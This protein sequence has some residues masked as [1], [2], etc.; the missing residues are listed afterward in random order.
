MVLHSHTILTFCEE[1]VFESL[2]WYDKNLMVQA[3]FRKSLILFI[4]IYITNRSIWYIVF[5]TKPTGCGDILGRP[6]RFDWGTILHEQNICLIMLYA[7]IGV[8]ETRAMVWKRR[9][10]PPSFSY[11]LWPSRLHPLFLCL[12]ISECFKAHF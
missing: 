3:L 6:S 5:S 7:N 10:V 4:K 2:F 12:N 9:G 1:L 11:K 8:A